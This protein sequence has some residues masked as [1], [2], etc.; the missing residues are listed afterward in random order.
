[1]LGW[2]MIFIHAVA[3]GRPARR[4]ITVIVL[5]ADDAL[6]KSTMVL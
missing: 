1:M 3:V 5:E 6:R 2:E 4:R